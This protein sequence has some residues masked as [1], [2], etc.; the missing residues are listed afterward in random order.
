VQGGAGTSASASAADP[1]PPAGAG[2]PARTP[3]Q[4]S[5]PPS[6]T[7]IYANAKNYFYNSDYN[8]AIRLLE[9]AIKRF[10][11][12]PEAPM[13]QVLIGDSHDSLGHNQEAL[14]AYGLVIKNYTD[15]ERVA[16]ALYKQ[17]STYEKLNQKDNAIKSYQDCIQ[18]FGPTSSMGILSTTALK[19]LG[20]IK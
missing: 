9:D 13:A 18:R 16:E 17:G 1:N 14:A 2:A 7:A 20:V 11:D 15:P 12:S 5:I 8:S 4:T 19:R 6:P 10:P 3:V